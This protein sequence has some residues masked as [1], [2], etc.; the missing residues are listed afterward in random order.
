MLAIPLLGHVDLDGPYAS[1]AGKIVSVGRFLEDVQNL[2]QRLP[3]RRYMLNLCVDRYEFSVGFCAA[4]LRNHISLLPPNYTADFVERLAMLY[5]ALYCLSDGKAEFPNITTVVYTPVDSQDSREIAMPLIPADRC[6]AVVFTSGSTGD[7]TPHEKTWGSLCRGAEVEAERFGI[8]PGCAMAVL[9]TVPGQ[10]MYGLESTVLL[11]MRNGLMLVAERPFYPADIAEQ[12]GMLPQPR[13]LITTPIHLRS[14]LAEISDVPH[15]DFVL[16]ATAHLPVD[17]AQ[18]AELL[19]SAPLYEIYGCTEAGQVASRRPTISPSW[20]LL[21]GLQMKQ[22]DGIAWVSGGH[23]EIAAKMNDVIVMESESSFTLNGRLA[24]LVNIAGKRTSL[25]SLNHHLV[26][27]SGVQDGVFMMP[28]ESGDGVI[29]PVAF[30][31]ASGVTHEDIVRAL[32]TCVDAVFLPRKICF[33]DALPRNSTG[34]LT[35]DSLLQLLKNY[36]RR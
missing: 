3:D 34:K 13:C 20:T 28:D 2:A 1:C 36:S 16:C 9:G 6:A 32:R 30:V 29:R 27:I 19:L 11:A 24:D 18:Q 12:L 25:N 10:H 23:A 4:L 21:P 26:N 15:V 7:P 33:V 14:L 31:V 17:L 8:V 5:P 35:R 22:D